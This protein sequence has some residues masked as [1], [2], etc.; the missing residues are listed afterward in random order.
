MM[1]R[2]CQF[3][4]FGIRVRFFFLVMTVR[5]S[6]LGALGTLAA[7][8]ALMALALSFS[9]RLATLGTLAASSAAARIMVVR[10]IVVRIMVLVVT[11]AT[12]R[13]NSP[14]DTCEKNIVQMPRLFIWLNVIVDLVETICRRDDYGKN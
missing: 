4:V 6:A 3:T 1:V 7:L 11:D 5:L 10:I 13:W 12:R 8:V 14:I 2:F 9:V